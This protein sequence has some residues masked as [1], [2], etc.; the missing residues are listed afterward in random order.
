MGDKKSYAQRIVLV[1]VVMI[2]LMTGCKRIY[3][4]FDAY[5]DLGSV[6]LNSLIGIEGYIGGEMPFPADIEI[7]EKDNYGREL[8]IYYEGGDE[9]SLLIS[10]KSD[11]EYVYFYPDYNF[12][13]ILKSKGTG[14]NGMEGGIDKT[15]FPLEEI[16]KLKEYN[17]WNREIDIEKCVKVEIVDERVNGPMEYKVLEPIYYELFGDDSSN[18]EYCTYF[19]TTDDNGR[20]IYAFNS[21]EGKKDY[22]EYHMIVLLKPDGT[23]DEAKGVMKLM[24]E[25]Y[26]YQDKLKE[27]KELNDWNKPIK[28]NY[29]K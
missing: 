14:A 12:V 4:G 13:T 25:E 1:F 3:T 20:S 29:G 11:R 21:Y 26:N 6:A 16:E 28:E 23:Y 24:S 7:V 15:N 10:Q 9:Y 19:L 2:I 18:I 22:E 8:F 17:D 5:A 27:F